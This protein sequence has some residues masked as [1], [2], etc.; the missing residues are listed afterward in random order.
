MFWEG[1]DRRWALMMLYL[2]IRSKTLLE[3][4]FSR[5]D[6]PSVQTLHRPPRPLYTQGLSQT[7]LLSAGFVQD[8]P[9][10]SAPVGVCTSEVGRY[11]TSSQAGSRVRLPMM[12]DRAINSLT[13]K[14]ADCKLV[15]KQHTPYFMPRAVLLRFQQHF[16]CAAGWEEHLAAVAF[17]V[18]RSGD[19][20]LP[21]KSPLFPT[22]PMW[23]SRNL[24]ANEISSG[25]RIV[26]FFFWL[27]F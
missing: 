21:Y 2:S 20:S 16:C 8:A 10:R 1:T 11:G 23:S 18:V 27:V 25:P 5:N 3:H 19:T 13:L 17:P 9:P 12:L 6:R 26:S 15:K 4:T 7:L 14:E 24:N 22:Q